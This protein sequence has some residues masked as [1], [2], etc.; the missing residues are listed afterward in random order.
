MQQ[1]FKNVELG[2]VEK[3]YD[4]IGLF[5]SGNHLNGVRFI[6]GI[7]ELRI[8]KADGVTKWLNMF[9]EKSVEF[10][11]RKWRI[12]DEGDLELIVNVFL[13]KISKITTSHKFSLLRRPHPLSL[14]LLEKSTQKI[15]CL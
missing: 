5:R 8:L 2:G 9:C 7:M 12:Q 10:L 15:L 3:N 6:S 14:E 1:Y 4:S 11:D 13:V